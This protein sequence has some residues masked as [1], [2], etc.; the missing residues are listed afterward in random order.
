M[1]LRKLNTK[2]IFA[3]VRMIRKIGLDS[4]KGCIGTLSAAKP[5]KSKN[6]REL[7]N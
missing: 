3:M 5:G 6:V 7:V 1:E 4:I 2:D